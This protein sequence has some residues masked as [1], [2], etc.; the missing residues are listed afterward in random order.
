[1]RKKKAKMTILA[2]SPRTIL[3]PQIAQERGAGFKIQHIARTRM[4]GLKSHQCQNPKAESTL[5]LIQSPRTR[6]GTKHQE[7]A[8]LHRGTRTA[9]CRLQKERRPYLQTM[10]RVGGLSCAL[11][12]EP[13]RPGSRGKAQRQS[14]RIGQRRYNR[15]TA[16]MMVRG[17]SQHLKGQQLG[18]TIRKKPTGESLGQGQQQPLS[19]SL[20][21]AGEYPA[22]V[23]RMFNQT[24]WTGRR[25][26]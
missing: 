23:S 17:I 7:I 5:C 22:W 11:L 6:E 16:T 13:R 18:M 24:P 9:C 8:L 12:N 25:R 3:K 15:A 10:M 26:L 21:E 1:M 2:T 20:V 4:H 14:G 19:H